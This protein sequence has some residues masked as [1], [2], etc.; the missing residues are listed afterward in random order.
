MEKDTGCL[1]NK[2][3]I[4]RVI[5]ETLV[6]LGKVPLEVFFPSNYSFTAIWRPFLGLDKY[7][8]KVSPKTVSSLLSR[9]KK[10][11][12]VDRDGKRRS[13]QWYLTP[14]GK[15]QCE[16]FKTADRVIEVP[17]PD[18]IARLVI[19]DIPE[20]ERNKRN[21]IRAELI[22]YNFTRLQKSVWI[23]YNPLPQSFIALIDD[24]ELKNKI[25][26]FSIKEMGTIK[27]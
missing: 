23:G 10:Q 27:D 22:A 3:T 15:R 26:I 21:I 12:L 13:Y 5:L 19:F 16:L 24:L 7:P 14:K 25:H 2:N 9:L 18:G 1:I 4:T 20:Y 17:Q 6:E 11:G 8:R